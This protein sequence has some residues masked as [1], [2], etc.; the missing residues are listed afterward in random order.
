M[1]ECVRLCVMRVKWRSA[2]VRCENRKNRQRWLYRYI[3][4]YIYIERERIKLLKDN[5]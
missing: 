4:I 3:C 2:I 1:R 5:S